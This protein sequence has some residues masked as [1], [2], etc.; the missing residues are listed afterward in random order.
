MAAKFEEEVKGGDW[1]KPGAKGFEAFVQDWKKN[2][3]DH[4]LDEYTRKTYMAY[5][6]THLIPA[7]WA[8]P[9]G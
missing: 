9:A 6:N 4:N 5:I 2:Y 1:V 7:F 8:L 3:A